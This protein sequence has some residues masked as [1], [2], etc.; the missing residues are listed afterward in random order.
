MKQRKYFFIILAFFPLTIVS[1][2]L[3]GPGTTTDK[4]V[5]YSYIFIFICYWL[6]NTLYIV[7]GNVGFFKKIKDSK[8]EREEE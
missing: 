5:F 2:W 8:H 6:W 4:V 3:F 1:S 7:R